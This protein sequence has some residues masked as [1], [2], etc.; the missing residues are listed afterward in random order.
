MGRAGLGLRNQMWPVIWSSKT[1]D[2]I[3]GKGWWAPPWT[4]GVQK[5]SRESKIL[6]DAPP[7]RSLSVG[8]PPPL[9]PFPLLNC[10]V[11]F[12]TLLS[13]SFWAVPFMLYLLQKSLLDQVRSPSSVPPLRCSRPAGHCWN[14]LLARLNPC[15]AWELQAKEVSPPWLPTACPAPSTRP[16]ILKSASVGLPVESDSL[17]PH[18]V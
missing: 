7:F 1:Q 4:P 6:L 18:G 2:S 16:S 8:T 15:L 9:P 11:C 17:Q 14:H 3:C 13:D 5:T 12:S 10:W